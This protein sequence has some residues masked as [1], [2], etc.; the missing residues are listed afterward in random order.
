MSGERIAPSM[1]ML[2][3]VHAARLRQEDVDP[4]QIHRQHRVDDLEA[5]LVHQRAEAL[6][7]GDERF[8]CSSATTSN[9]A[10]R[11]SP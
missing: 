11:A 3:I 4:E 7:G 10:L 8:D 6:V 2:G 1:R 9:W 5:L